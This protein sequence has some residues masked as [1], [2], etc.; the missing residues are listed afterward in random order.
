MRIIL[1][2]GKV[3][4][5]IRQPGD[6]VFGHDVVEVT[7]PDSIYVALV[8]TLSEKPQAVINTVGK[9]NL[10]WCESNPS[11]ASMVNE[12]GALNVLRACRYL[13]L[14]LVHLSSGCIFDGGNQRK[15]FTESDIPTP[16]CHYAVTKARADLA[17]LAEGYPKLTVVRPRQLFSCQPSPT[18]LI[19]KFAAMSGGRFVTSLQSATCIEDLGA[20]ISHLIRGQHYGVFN[21]ANA[22]FITPLVMAQ[23]IAEELETDLAPEAIDYDTYVATLGVK[24]VNTLLCI[25]RLR[26]TGFEPRDV[27]EA[28]RWALENYH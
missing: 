20:M 22:G 3:A 16:A 4:S 14:P 21:C 5:V 25:E 2:S 23:L 9:I 24:R 27:N 8:K 15:V 7:D 6:V 11:A 26:A 13:N 19:T 12:F 18:N 28:F 17:L 10:E 1:G